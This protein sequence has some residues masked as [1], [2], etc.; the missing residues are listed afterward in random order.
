[1]FDWDM[2]YAQDDDDPSRSAKSCTPV[3]HALLYSVTCTVMVQSRWQPTARYT[4]V[5]ITHERVFIGTSI[6]TKQDNSSTQ[7]NVDLSVSNNSKRGVPVMGHFFEVPLQEFELDRFILDLLPY[8]RKGMANPEWTRKMMVV[9]GNNHLVYRTIDNHSDLLS[10]LNAGTVFFYWFHVFTQDEQVLC[11][12]GTA[13]RPDGT[14]IEEGYSADDGSCG[15][16]L[17]HGFVLA[18][19]KDKLT[20]DVATM[21]K[22]TDMPKSDSSAMFMTNRQAFYPSMLSFLKKFVKA[23]MTTPPTDRLEPG[24]QQTGWDPP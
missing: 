4:N 18:V 2:N 20:V 21:C 11:Q 8:R 16:R 3:L 1:M 5:L 17:A 13:R 22:C 9:I 19:S 7:P 10:E 23:P 15:V 14:V 24:K 12:D 6:M